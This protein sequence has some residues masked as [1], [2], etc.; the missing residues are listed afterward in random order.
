MGEEERLELLQSL[1]RD[2]TT[3]QIGIIGKMAYNAAENPDRQHD[4]IS[5]G[6]RYERQVVFSLGQIC[7]EDGDH[8]TTLSAAMH[9]HALG[10]YANKR[11]GNQLLKLIREKD[12][13]AF[14]EL[15]E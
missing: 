2:L 10:G 7:M 3:G 13:R 11:K 14:A 6:P 5:N 1:P 12:E 9:L 15:N 4:G 8:M